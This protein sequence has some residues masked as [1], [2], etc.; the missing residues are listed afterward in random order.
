MRKSLL[1]AVICLWWITGAAQIMK[2]PSLEDA[3]KKLPARPDSWWLLDSTWYSQWNAG[4]AAWVLNERE[5]LSYTSTGALQQDLYLNINTITLTWDNW[6]RYI[7]TYLSQ[8]GIQW[9]A[10]Q[11][12]DTFDHIWKDV[13]YYHYNDQG[14]IDTSFYKTYD[15][16]HNIFLNGS[17][18]IV[19]YNANHMYVETDYQNLD[20]ATSNWVNQSKMLYTYDASN[21][22]TELISQNWNPGTSSWVNSSKYDYT[23]DANGVATGFTEY[24]WNSGSSTWVNLELATYLNDVNGLPTQKLYQL[25][26]SGSTAWVNQEI[27][28][29][30]YNGSNQLTQTL[31]LTWS[32]A[33]A[34]W[35]NNTKDTYSY[36]TSGIQEEHY[37]YFWNPIGV[38]YLDTYYN[39][40]DSIGYPSEFYSKNIDYSTYQYTSGYKYLYT[41]TSQHRPLVILNQSLSIP[42]LIWKDNS[43]RT[44][45]YDV[46]GNCITETD[47]QYDSVSVQWVNTF[48]QDHFYTMT[49]GIHE[50]PKVS[51]YCFFSNP[52][53]SGQSVVCPDLD[54]GKSY[55]ILL[56]NMMGQLIQTVNLHAGESF[57]IK[58]NLSPGM[59]FIQII[60][61]GKD[62]ASGKV[63]IH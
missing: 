63:I 5:F 54:A 23:F 30:T 20:T 9:Q 37:Q 55:Q 15:P 6:T 32:T 57:T 44:D 34:S 59:Y 21:R 8:G 31:D 52:M 12:W 39:L 41:Y 60:E 28:M 26:N 25:W 14:L 10:N 1:L 47:Q 58:Q 7:Y 4:T 51:T 50:K 56:L 62:V 53:Q 27:T 33:L 45:T 46:N 38:N 11:D 29:Y 35:V 16:T 43:R 18:S 13:S 36:Y 2:V 3:L 42:S 48:R 19:T 17:R 24:S 49:T 22:L 61:N 40:N